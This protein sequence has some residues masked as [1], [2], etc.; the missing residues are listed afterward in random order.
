MRARSWSGI[1]AIASAGVLA[2]AQG[3]SGE[4]AY[5]QQTITLVV[6]FAAGGLADGLARII[7]QRL[8]DRF[9]Q[10]VVIENRSGAGG[11]VAAR[12]VATAASD[13]YTLL[14]TTTAIA[15]NDTLY[16]RKGYETEDLKPVA[17][18]ATTP[19]LIAVNAGSPIR[20][21]KELLQ[22]ARARSMTFGSAGVGTGSFIAAQYFFKALAQV[23][24]VH[25]PF[26]GGAPAIN[27]AI[28][29][30]VDVLAASMPPV[31]PHVES[32]ALRALALAAPVR[33]PV[34]PDVPTFEEL[35]YPGFHAASWVG[36]FAPAG[37]DREVMLRLNTALNDMLRESGMKTWL[38]RFGLRPLH[39]SERE[40]AQLL[41]AEI[42]TWGRMVRTL[43]LAAD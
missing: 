17:I 38:K 42:E 37:T 25:V 33:S 22:T 34:L 1:V 21:L 10:N 43:G 14:V 19:E 32:G 26:A 8:T 35:G 2:L 3:A 9:G 41:R 11:T 6:A 20:T 13:G 39:N 40:A 29:R 5:P 24:V 30:H 27:A 16:K 23:D 36:V 4:T 7:G 12:A 18:I 28:G 31:V 15:I